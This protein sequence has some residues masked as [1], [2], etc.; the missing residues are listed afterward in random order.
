MSRPASPHRT[1]ALATA[2]VGAVAFVALAALFIPWH[3]VPG[4]MPAPAPASSVL[5]RAE[6]G[7]AESWSAWARVWSWSGLAV[8]ILVPALL[9]FTRH[10]RRLVDRLPGRW[11]VQVVLAVVV[12]ELAVRLA[13]LPMAV[14]QQQH[15][16]DG[17]LTRQPWPAFALDVAENL[18][19]DTVVVAVLVLLLVACAR[20]WR[21]AW[22][23]VAGGLVGVLVLLGAFVYPVVVEPLFNSF[24]PLPDGPLRT[25]VL[26]LA[27]REGVTVD[28]VLVADASRRTTTLN[29]YVSG[30]G[31]TRR[32]V[33]YD[34]LV[35]EVP[36]RQVLS[37][38]GH[39]LAHAKHEDP[40]VGA[41]VGVAGALLGVGLLGL[42]APRLREPRS[43]PLVLALL[44]LGSFLA[45]P[46]QNA[47][48]R[49]V[50][51][52]AD[53]AALRYTHDPEAF[54]A[55]QKQLMVHSLAD[56]TPPA[57]SQFWF[58]SHPT[59]LQ[60]IAIARRLGSTG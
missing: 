8:S 57:P 10:G 31:S 42:L 40:L 22:P 25:G 41:L 16:I 11:P 58:G 23:A 18:L 1:V 15:A 35:H 46:V 37:V 55:V 3:P 6:V 9:G 49:Q 13:T 38:V 12:V 43:V 21:R 28:D 60:R 44:A 14:A 2:G 4:G 30:F 59:G 32:V 45:L 17:G 52:R 50:E 5:T 27:R 51:T 33:L 26:A 48:S 39:E 53:V 20:R 47:L 54:V 36:R 34:N 19:L 56:P 29:A 24:H 7:R